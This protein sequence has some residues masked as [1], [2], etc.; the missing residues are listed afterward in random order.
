MKTPSVRTVA[1]MGLLFALAIVLSFLE[2]L[3]PSLVP[4]VP[5]IKLGLSN[6]VTMYCLFFLGAR[7]A[8]AV[9]ALKSLFVLLTRGPAGAAMSFA[10]GLLSLAV[11][12]CC[13]R[14][15]SLGE[16]L[17]S[18]AGAIAH[19]VGQLAMAGLLLR[20]VFA[21]YYLPVMILSGILMGML[22]GLLLRFV[23]PYLRRADEAFK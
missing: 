23:M 12:L 14:L 9:A 19:N 8:F 17:T 11:M 16:R 13:R 4:T 5:G 1:S 20:S 6:I 21:F 7:P 22:T 10:G 3:I 18:I 2:H 15:F